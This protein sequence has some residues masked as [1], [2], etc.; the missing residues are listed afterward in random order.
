[1]VRRFR[2]AL[3]IL[4]AVGFMSCGEGDSSDPGPQFVAGSVDVVPRPSDVK[5]DPAGSV[6][7]FDADTA[8]ITG[9]GGRSTRRG[10]PAGRAVARSVPHLEH[11]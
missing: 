5:V 11:L 10:R 4:S 2:R 1:M 6:F 3:I 8:V 7:V 9:R